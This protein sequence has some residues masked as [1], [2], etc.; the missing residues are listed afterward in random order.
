MGTEASKYHRRMSEAI[1][2][3]L[4]KDTKLNRGKGYNPLPI[5]MSLLRE[6]GA[7]KASSWDPVH[8][9][10]R[11]LCTLS[12]ILLMKEVVGFLNFK[13]SAGFPFSRCY[14][15]NVVCLHHS[16]H[17]KNSSVMFQKEHFHWE[18]HAHTSDNKGMKIHSCHC[19]EFCYAG[20]YI[21]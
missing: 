7:S 8:T 10:K 15:W 16:K 17:S 18:K 11:T 9:E 3:R 14:T 21:H 20:Y 1:Y 5:H 12:H 19:S 4:I 13:V 2:I 6:K